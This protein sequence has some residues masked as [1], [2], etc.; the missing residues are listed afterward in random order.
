MVKFVGFREGESGISTYPLVPSK[1]NAPLS[2][3]TIPA[4]APPWRDPLLRPVRSLA[5]LSA[6]HQLTKPPGTGV[7]P[8]ASARQ[9]NPRNAAAKIAAVHCRFIRNPIVP[10]E[11]KVGA[12]T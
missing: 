4:V 2:N 12:S 8:A 9:A 10:I 5:L 6:G 3:V 1:L 11:P 7:Q